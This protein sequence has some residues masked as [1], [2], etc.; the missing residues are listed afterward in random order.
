LV[1]E[2]EEPTCIH[3]HSLKV[4]GEATVDAIT[5]YQSARR[6]K[7]SQTEE[8]KFIKTTEWLPLHYSDT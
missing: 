3:E 8:Q 7:E 1:A 2:C 4:H 6:I 5:V